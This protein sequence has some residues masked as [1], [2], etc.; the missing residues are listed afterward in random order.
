MARVKKAE[1]K[2]AEDGTIDFHAEAVRLATGTDRKALQLRLLNLTCRSLSL[3]EGEDQQT[4]VQAALDALAAINPRD[5]FEGIL[6]SQMVAVHE[7]AMDCLRRAQYPG[8]PFETRDMNLKN[9]AKLLQL[10]VRQVEA[11]DKH[12]GKGQQKITVEHVTVQA[13]GQAIV[14]HVQAG[15]RSNPPAIGDERASE[16]LGQAPLPSPR[17]KLSGSVPGQSAEK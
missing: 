9:A 2:K 14:G 17:R 10:Y 7:T 13:G 4:V 16:A 1:Q 15:E 12:R 11:L 8:Q 6:A 3:R 5:G